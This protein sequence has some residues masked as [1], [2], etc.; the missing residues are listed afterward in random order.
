[1]NGNIVDRCLK[2]YCTCECFAVF[3]WIDLE[4]V[5]FVHIIIA[6]TPNL[7]YNSF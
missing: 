2:K 4:T 7:H 6:G 3:D 5:C 1:M